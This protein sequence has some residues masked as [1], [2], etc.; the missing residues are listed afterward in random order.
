MNP[1][2]NLVTKSFWVGLKIR[3]YSPQTLEI[4][5]NSKTLLIERLDHTLLSEDLGQ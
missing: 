2:N 4:T 3:V 1:S 5:K